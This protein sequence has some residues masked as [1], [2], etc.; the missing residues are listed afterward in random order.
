MFNFKRKKY[1]KLLKEQIYWLNRNSDKLFKRSKKLYD[2]YV[3]GTLNKNINKRFC[4]F[5]L[6][7]EKCIEYNNL[8]V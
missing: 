7:E 4:N 8:L 5:K 3:N 1:V 2:S 6:L